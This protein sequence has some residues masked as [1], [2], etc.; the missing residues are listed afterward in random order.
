MSINFNDLPCDLKWMIF[1]INRRD[2][3][4]KQIRNYRPK[5]WPSGFGD[6][7]RYESMLKDDPK[8]YLTFSYMGRFDNLRATGFVY[9]GFYHKTSIFHPVA[10]K[11]YAIV[12]KI[13]MD[14]LEY[15]LTQNRINRY[16]SDSDSDD[17]Y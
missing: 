13:P 8:G 17:D 6:R 9:N 12:S 15:K 1:G 5:Y 16:D 7:Q 4:L 14:R 10:R 11:G 2:A 3:H